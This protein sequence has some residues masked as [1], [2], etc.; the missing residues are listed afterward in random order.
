MP[1]L[2]ISNDVIHVAQIPTIDVNRLQEGDKAEAAKL[3]KAS[4][5]DGILYLDFSDQK[6]M[7][8]IEAVWKGL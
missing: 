4:K 8:M 3:F 1:Q 2:F 5:E 6:C 7:K